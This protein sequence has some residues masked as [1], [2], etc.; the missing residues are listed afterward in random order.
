VERNPGPL[1]LAST[2][3]WAA[4]LLIAAMVGLDLYL[5][6]QGLGAVEF[7]AKQEG[8]SV[9]LEAPLRNRGYLPLGLNITLRLCQHRYTWSSTIPP[10]GEATARLRVDPRDLGCKPRWSIGV[11]LGDLVSAEIR[12]ASG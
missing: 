8:Q 10:G 7:K 9:Y 5:V 12:P 3:I 1:S 11:R 6:S 4:A 2:A